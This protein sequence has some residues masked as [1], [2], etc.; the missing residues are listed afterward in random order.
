MDKLREKIGKRLEQEG[1]G[2]VFTRKDFQNLSPVGTIGKFLF[3]LE[4]EGKI[5]RL[6]S[7]LFD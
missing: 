4:K 7:G 5:R 2:C 3:R 1:R 6:G